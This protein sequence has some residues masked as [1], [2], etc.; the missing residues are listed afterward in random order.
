PYPTTST[1]VVTTLVSGPFGGECCASVTNTTVPGGGDLGG[2]S[3]DFAQVG[4]FF[5][6][7][8]FGASAGCTVTGTS[9][10]ITIYLSHPIF[11]FAPNDARF[12]I[13]LGLLDLNGQSIPISLLDYNGFFGA[14]GLIAEL[15]FA[16]TGRCATTDDFVKMSLNDIVVA[17]ADEPS[18]AV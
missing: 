2:F 7:F 9:S 15:D 12:D 10:E 17:R 14:V 3:Y 4:Q 16:C 8:C 13:S 1:H 18:S 6:A 11:G 5:D